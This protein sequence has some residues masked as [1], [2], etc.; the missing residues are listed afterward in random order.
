MVVVDLEPPLDLPGSLASLGRWGDDG[1]DRWDGVRLLR[2]ARDGS[3][4]VPF[5]ARPTG[6]IDSPGLAVAAEVPDLPSATAMVATMFAPATPV[7]MES[8]ARRDAVMATLIADHP[9]IRPVIH[10][11]PLTA[12]VR[13]ISA[14]QINLTFAARLRGRLVQ[15]FGTSHVIAGETVGSLDAELVAA[16]APEELRELQFTTSKARSMIA[17]ARATLDGQ[18]GMAELAAMSDEAVGDR[19]RALPGIG[20]WTV[21]WFLAR[22]LARPRVAAGD[23]GVRKAVG[24]IYLAGRLPSEAEVRALTAHWGEAAGIAQQLI[25][26]D[27]AVRG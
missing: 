16:A 27:L 26:H 5:L 19:L 21:D 12:L 3:R 4:A 9:G 13:S 18:L 25:L 1:I 23:L 14:Q 2:T 7:A 22:T 8:L 20:P 10:P 24:R 11:D 6:S 15:A 17:V